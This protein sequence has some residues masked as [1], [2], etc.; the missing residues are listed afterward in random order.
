[1]SKYNF[2]FYT[3]YGYRGIAAYTIH[4]YYIGINAESDVEAIK[5]LDKKRKALIR[6]NEAFT[7]NKC[8]VQILKSERVG[9]CFI[10]D[11]IIKWQDEEVLASPQIFGIEPYRRK[12]QPTKYIFDGEWVLRNVLDSIYPTYTAWFSYV[13]DRMGGNKN[14][15]SLI[16]DTKS[17]LE[18]Y[19]YK[20]L[21]QMLQSS[22]YSEKEKDE[23]SNL[24]KRVYE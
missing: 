20:P 11:N 24:L 19:Y 18:K 12:I 10:E 1:M 23:F 17:E 3:G 13:W 16:S 6:F 15:I 9:C 14:F 5:K 21:K 2:V 8:G 7:N 4:P 22:S